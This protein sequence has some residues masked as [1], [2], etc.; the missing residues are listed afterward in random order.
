MQMEYNKVLNSNTKQKVFL[1]RTLQMQNVKNGI[2]DYL[3]ELHR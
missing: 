2:D 1:W 3:N